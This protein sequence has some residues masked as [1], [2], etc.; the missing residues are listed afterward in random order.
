MSNVDLM[1]ALHKRGIPFSQRDTKAELLRKLG[2][3]SKVKPRKPSKDEDR[4]ASPEKF[5]DR[6]RRNADEKPKVK[7]V[8]KKP[9]QLDARK[10]ERKGDFWTS[11]ADNVVARANEAG[12]VEFWERVRKNPDPVQR[13]RRVAARALTPRPTVPAR[14]GEFWAALPK[15]PAKKKPVARSLAE[16]VVDREAASELSNEAKFRAQQARLAKLR[17]EQIPA[18]RRIQLEAPTSLILGKPGTS[19]ILKLKSAVPGAALPVSIV[20]WDEPLIPL[21]EPGALRRAK[22]ES[23][24]KF[25][26]RVALNLEI[27]VDRNNRIVMFNE[28]LLF[29]LEAET[30]FSLALLSLD[31]LQQQ[32]EEFVEF[33]NGV[34]EGIGELIADV[35]ITV[36]KKL[37]AR[38]AGQLVSHMP[39]SLHFT[40]AEVKDRIVSYWDTVTETAF[41]ERARML[42]E[43]A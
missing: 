40:N 43:S 13:V 1:C 16:I 17:S 22:K 37:L 35:R 9:A 5:W 30:S 19:E 29:Y 42:D 7:R 11:L 39:Y 4:T 26:K 20:L 10:E 15:G 33:T 23:E 32:L 25:A 24:E 28:I 18:T 12:V 3:A 34:T 21:E 36:S 27:V 6:V 31:T 8:A 38:I 2:T 14:E 41:A